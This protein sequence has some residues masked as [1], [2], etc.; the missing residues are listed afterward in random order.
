[1]RLQHLHI[2]NPIPYLAASRIQD[3]LVRRHLDF[4][5]QSARPPPP[6]APST[7]S[8]P[9]PSPPP[10]YL[11]TFQAA[12]TYTC[13]RREIPGITAA[14][15]AH[16]QDSGR[17]AFHP[18]LR[19]GQTTFHG[20]G[21]VTAYA[22]LALAAHRLTPRAHV[23]LLED[24]AVEACAAA[25]VRAFVT[26]NPGVWVSELAKIGAVGVHLR[27]GVSSHG[28]AL[29]VDV[30]LAWFERIVACGLVG[31][32]VTSLHEELG[33][34]GATTRAVSYLLAD[35]MARRLE[36]VDG[37]DTVELEGQPGD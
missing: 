13:G 22:V 29:N 11:L 35:I 32:R 7:P 19:G 5:A 2:V 24:A 6:T 3:V 26:H 28:L 20:P 16:L 36:G 30:D 10:P 23:R 27:R 18:A 33:T 14:Q 37:V 1:M 25:G 15:V 8:P 4:K 21:Q 31:K 17:A 34:S 9:A 12:P